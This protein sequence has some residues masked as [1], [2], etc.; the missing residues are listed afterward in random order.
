MVKFLNGGVID[1]PM[2]KFN[3]EV[4]DAEKHQVKVN[5][6]KLMKQVHIEVD[7]QMVINEPNFSPAVKKYEFDVGES[8]KHRVEISEG[9]FSPL[10][11]VVDG[12]QVK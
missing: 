12:K 1:I 3:F 9:L 5:F 6:S 8:E 4:G 10:K 7:G 2:S 11:V